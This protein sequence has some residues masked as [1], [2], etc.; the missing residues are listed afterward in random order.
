MWSRLEDNLM[1]KQFNADG[2]PLP[3]PDFMKKWR[4][5][6][7]RDLP[8]PQELAEHFAELIAA[9]RWASELDRIGAANKELPDKLTSIE[10]MLRSLLTCFSTIPVLMKDGA[11]APLMRLRAAIVDLADGRQSELFV[12]IIKKPGNPGKG[13]VHTALQGLAA[14]ALAELAIKQASDRVANA[15]RK[16]RKDMRDVTGETVKNWRKRLDEGPDGGAP[17]DALQHYIAPLPPEFGDTSKI[18]GERLLKALRER[19]EAIG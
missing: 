12:P 6:A 14:R 17:D 16:G 8:P 5:A 13:V 2:V 15:L 9:M 10:Y 4:E 11:L 18:R 3:D 19:G 7:L 1:T